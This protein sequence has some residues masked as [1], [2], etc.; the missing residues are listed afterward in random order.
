MGENLKSEGAM[1]SQG[2]KEQIRE[3]ILTKLAKKKL[4][5]DFPENV[6]LLDSGIIDSLGIMQLIYYIENTFSIKID[7]NELL[8]ENFESIDN[9]TKLV[10]GKTAVN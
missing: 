1:K 8:P 7:D 4:N 9:I 6:N 5:A 2:E 10:A 3:F